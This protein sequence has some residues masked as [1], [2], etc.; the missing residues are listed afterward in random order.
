MSK[1]CD[2]FKKQKLRCYPIEIIDK[3]EK[4]TGK[5][6]CL[7]C[8]KPVEIAIKVREMENIIKDAMGDKNYP[9]PKCQYKKTVAINEEGHAGVYC[10]DCG[11]QL[12]KEC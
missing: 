11:E 4:P 9:L 10:L 12:E 7:Y 8:H 5:F 1:Y 3:E 6:I 2:F